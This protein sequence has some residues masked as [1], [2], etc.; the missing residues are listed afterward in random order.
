MT[1][2]SVFK[3]KINELVVFEIVLKVKIQSSDIFFLYVN[4]PLGAQ[5]VQPGSNRPLTIL[6]QISKSD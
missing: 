3:V 5:N 4:V 6:V 2:S 1:I